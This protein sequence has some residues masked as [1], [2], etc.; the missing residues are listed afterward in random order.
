MSSEHATDIYRWV[1]EK[2]DQ[3]DEDERLARPHKA[4][5]LANVLSAWE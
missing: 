1:F 4:G 3:P 2:A 5:S